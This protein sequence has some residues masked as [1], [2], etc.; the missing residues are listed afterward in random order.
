MTHGVLKAFMHQR[1]SQNLELKE[2]RGSDSE[3]PGTSVLCVHLKSEYFLIMVSNQ[4]QPPFKA[5][6]STIS[7]W[8]GQ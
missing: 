5:R 2:I 6:G 7:A 1:W 3:K 4:R 8:A